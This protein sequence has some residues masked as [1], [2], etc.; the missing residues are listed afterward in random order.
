MIRH[1]VIA[2]VGEHLRIPKGIETIPCQ[3]CFVLAGIW[4]AHVH[5]M[6]PQWNEAANQPADKLARP[7]S[8]MLTHSASDSCRYQLGRRDTIALRRRV[9]T[10]EVTGTAHNDRG[11]PYL[12]RAC[13][14]VLPG[15]PSR[16]IQGKDGQP[17]TAADAATIVDKNRA[18]GC[19][20]VSSSPVRLCVQSHHSDA[21]RRSRV[22]R[23]MR[24]IDTGRWSLRIPQTLRRTKWQSTP[25]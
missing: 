13:I 16:R 6:E 1:G 17:E 24:H 8:E 4:N 3:G 23:L 18:A 2:E 15:G 19:D 11:H 9:E 21:S 14:A 20:I 22:R 12:S 7:M 25:V 10:G 5:F